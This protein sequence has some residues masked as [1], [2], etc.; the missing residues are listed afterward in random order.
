[1]TVAAAWREP[2]PEHREVI[3]RTHLRGRTID[4]AAEIPRVLDEEDREA[5]QG[6]RMA[7]E[8]RRIELREPSEVLGRLDVVR[9]DRS[10]S[11][12]GGRMSH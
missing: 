12:D 3:E 6:H 8:E 4:E 9:R 10:N 7:G 11:M 2:A 5:F 1:M